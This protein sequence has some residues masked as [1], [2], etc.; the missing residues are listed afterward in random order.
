[1]HAGY[2]FFFFFLENRIQHFMQIVSNGD[3]KHA[4]SSAPARIL[5]HRGAG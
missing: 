2:F 4:M 3:N 5:G 1:M